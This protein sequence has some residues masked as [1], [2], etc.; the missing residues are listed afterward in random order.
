[1]KN[2][3]QINI[4]EITRKNRLFAHYRCILRAD[5]LIEKS[6]K[7]ILTAF[8]KKELLYLNNR[9]TQ[10]NSQPHMEVIPC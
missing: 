4:L 10:I 8:E 7:S 9:L 3:K 1:M 6:R 2:N 5:N